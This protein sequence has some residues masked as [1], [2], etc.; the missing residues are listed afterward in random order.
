MTTIVRNTKIPHNP[1]IV[2]GQ[3]NKAVDSG[4]VNGTGVYSIGSSRAS[5]EAFVSSGGAKPDVKTLV[6]GTGLYGIGAA[7]KSPEAFVSAGGERFKT[8]YADELTKVAKDAAK[9]ASGLD[10]LMKCRDLGD[11]SLAALANDSRM[12][13]AIHRAIDKMRGQVDSIIREQQA[14]Q[15]NDDPTQAPITGQD[16]GIPWLAMDADTRLQ[17]EQAAKK[18]ARIRN[19]STEVNPARILFGLPDDVDFDPVASMES[20]K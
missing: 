7:R 19:A 20:K 6:N 5:S 2:K 14:E 3:K 4:L 11:A 10:A 13:R 12:S 18:A 15:N 9:L 17:M 16:A 1:R 8:R